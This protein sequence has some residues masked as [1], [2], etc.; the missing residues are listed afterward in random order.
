MALNITAPIKGQLIFT[1]TDTCK[2]SSIFLR[3]SD[4]N[5]FS[6]SDW[7]PWASKTLSLVARRLQCHYEQGNRCHGQHSGPRFFYRRRQLQTESTKTQMMLLINK[8]TAT[9]STSRRLESWCAYTSH[10]QRCDVIFHWWDKSCIHTHF[11]IVSLCRQN[12]HT[13]PAK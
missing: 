5:S 4:I 2:H 10:T 6:S 3:T 12:F 8:F 13:H 11:S 1:F 9:R 7:S